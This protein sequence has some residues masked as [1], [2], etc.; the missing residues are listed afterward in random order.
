MLW[1]GTLSRTG[2]LRRIPHGTRMLWM[3]KGPERNQGQILTEMSAYP[4]ISAV[5][6]LIFVQVAIE[7][8]GVNYGDFIV[9]YCPECL[10]KDHRNSLVGPVSI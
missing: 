7:H 2:F 6:W 10:L 1:T 3:L 9:P 5:E 4:L 8:L